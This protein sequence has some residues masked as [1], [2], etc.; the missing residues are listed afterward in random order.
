MMGNRP[1]H[2]GKKKLPRGTT[3]QNHEHSEWNRAASGNG[4]TLNYTGTL[5]S[6]R[7][8]WNQAIVVAKK[9]VESK[10][11]QHGYNIFARAEAERTQLQGELDRAVAIGSVTRTMMIAAAI[12]YGEEQ[13]D[14][15][16][17]AVKA[18]LLDL[19]ACIPPKEIGDSC[20][21]N[22]SQDGHVLVL[23]NGKEDVNEPSSTDKAAE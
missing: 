8:S 1:K 15:T 11:I 21:L 5:N 7:D 20:S 6:P 16:T 19:S 22:I 18:W 14:P 13:R 17:G 10:H 12:R 2:S 4:K 23:V 9:M 3:A